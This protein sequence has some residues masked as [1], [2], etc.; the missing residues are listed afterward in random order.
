VEGGCEEIG[1]IVSLALSFKESVFAKS[2]GGLI[3]PNNL[4]RGKKK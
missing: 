2:G 3:R 4:R 1:L